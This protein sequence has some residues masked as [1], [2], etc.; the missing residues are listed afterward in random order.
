[1]ALTLSIVLRLPAKL[2]LARFIQIPADSMFQMALSN[3][4]SP[5]LKKVAVVTPV[6]TT[7]KLI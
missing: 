2:E 3:E 4:I 1:M 7:P 5:R 6:R